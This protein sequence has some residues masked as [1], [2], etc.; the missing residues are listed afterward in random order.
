MVCVLNNKG[1]RMNFIYGKFNVF[2]QYG[3]PILVETNNGLKMRFSIWNYDII[4]KTKLYEWKLDLSSAY[5]YRILDQN[6]KVDLGKTLG[7]LFL[8][9]MSDVKGAQAIDFSIRGFEK[10]LKSRVQI[11]WSDGSYIVLDVL[12]SEGNSLKEKLSGL[13]F[14]ESAVK[15]FFDIHQSIEEMVVDGER[16]F[17]ELKNE[18]WKL[19]SEY[20]NKS[21]EID[22]GDNFEER[23]KR[24]EIVKG[25]KSDLIKKVLYLKGLSY[26]FNKNI[27]GYEEIKSFDNSILS[28]S[29]AIIQPPSDINDNSGSGT[30]SVSEQSSEN[31]NEEKIAE[32]G[33]SN[34][35]EQ[36]FEELKGGY[37]VI[38]LIYI[39]IS[40]GIYKFNWVDLWGAINIATALIALTWGR[41]K[42]PEL[43]GKFPDKFD[44][45]TNI[46]RLYLEAFNFKSRASRSEFWSGTIFNFLFFWVYIICLILAL[47]DFVRE[48]PIKVF[49][50]FLVVTGFPQLSL[51]VRRLHDVNKSGWWAIFC[52]SPASLIIM[53]IWFLQ[54]S[55]KQEGL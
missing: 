44:V 11:F 21:S 36:S 53:L 1:C 26:A 24:R 14:G 16:V 47:G 2:D 40:W 50:L 25:L 51:I 52:F 31:N 8:V 48:N 3:N 29:T 49:F 22:L 19:K 5:A 28:I 17:Y 46:E 9:G 39:I 37:Y 45:V 32:N 30:L 41:S 10:K 54:Q 12:G 20:E 43:Y 15:K 23:R 38:S 42:I 34:D 33:T 27:E 7:R 55:Y 35:K 18:I 13:K 4:L 6:E